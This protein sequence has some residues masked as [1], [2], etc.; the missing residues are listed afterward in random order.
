MKKGVKLC[1][2]LFG[3][4]LLGGVMTACGGSEPSQVQFQVANGY[5]Q[6]QY[7]GDTSWNNL[8]SVAD[9]KGEKGDKGTT[10]SQGAAGEKGE[11]GN[12]GLSAYEIAVQQGFKGDEKDWLQSL[13]G[14]QG[15]SGK[16]AYDIAV[17]CGFEGSKDEWL[18][19]LKGKDGKSAYQI[20][21]DSGF[22]GSQQEWLDSLKGANG[23]TGKTVYQI[24]QEL[25]FKGTEEEWLKTLKGE[26]GENGYSPYIGENGNWWINQ[27]DTGVAVVIKNMDRTGTDGLSFMA[28]IRNGIAGYEVVGYDGTETDI[29]IPNRL[30]DKPVISIKQDV[31]P[32]SIT[33][34][35]ISSNTEYLPLFTSYSKLQTFDFNNAPINQVSNE[36]FKNAGELS[37]ILNY[38]NI[39]N[40]GEYAFYATKV[41]EF[42]YSNL[43]TIGSYAFYDVDYPQELDNVTSVE[44]LE[45]YLQ[46]YK[47]YIYIPETVTEIGSNAFSSSVMHPVYYGGSDVD[48]SSSYFYDNVKHTD[49]GYYYREY[50]TYTQL[51]N[52][53]GTQT[54]IVVPDTFGGKP[55]G[56]YFL[57][58]YAFYNNAVIERVDL[59]SSVQL[60][61]EQVDD[62]GLF[63]TCYHLHSVVASGITDWDNVEALD[64][65]LYTRWDRSGTYYKYAQV[66]RYIVSYPASEIEDDEKFIYRKTRNIYE[67]YYELLGIKNVQGAVEI[68]ATHNGLPVRKIVGGVLGDTLTT[69]V[70]IPDS[71]TKISSYA[72]AESD[73]LLCLSIPNSVED[74]NNRGLYDLSNCT[75]FVEHKTIP[76]DWDAEWYSSVKKIVMD[77]AECGV[78]SNGDYL[79]KIENGNLYLVEY[80]GGQYGGISWGSTFVVP[81]KIDGMNVYGIC[82]SCFKITGYSNSSSDSNRYKIVVP[83]SI[84]VIESKAFYYQN[85]SYYNYT[86]LYLGFASESDIPSTWATDWFYKSNYKSYLYTYYYSEWEMVD[87]EAELKS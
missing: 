69:S 40:I 79:Y 53:D 49:T 23:E 63:D 75:V 67:E 1:A 18:Q 37:E 2:A 59:P 84:V 55:L 77:V 20:A 85:S 41:W 45:T 30:F 86:N 64:L 34:L 27:T 48:Y 74:V 16:S 81:D 12:T 72:F 36:M 26:Q 54:H 25:G 24:A 66:P 61:M 28:V 57:E 76:D 56:G 39:K 5:I 29:V 14:N 83:A 68:P 80:I 13:I 22:I 71:V 21:L 4:C 50:D 47:G 46:K 33:S 78:S 52:Y 35:S 10:G 17:E 8:I 73:T 6:W 58:E 82:S 32:K 87:G 15:A 62:L 44:Q 7:K 9:L 51:L 43:E 60:T 3:V 19:S 65:G 38:K 31:L 11:Q 70:E 42:D